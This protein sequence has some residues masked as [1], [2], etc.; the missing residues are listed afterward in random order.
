[1]DPDE[2]AAL[3]RGAV[4]RGLLLGC[5][6]LVSLLVL[7]GLG[8]AMLG[9]G[10]GTRAEATADEA[11][12]PLGPP[13][14][15]SPACAF[16]LGFAEFR[17][18][19]PGVVGACLGDEA[20]DPASGNTVQ[21]TTTGMLEWRRADGLVAFTDGHR[22]WVRGPDGA[23][24][25]RYNDERFP[26]EAEPPGRELRVVTPGPPLVPGTPAAPATGSPDPGELRAYAAY[27]APRF[28]ALTA[29]VT[30]LTELTEEAGRRPAAVGEEEWRAR[31]AITLGVLRVAGTE[32][33][34]YDPV[35]ERLRVLD[36][37]VVEV[38]RELVLVV[39]EFAQGLDDQDTGR[40]ANAARHMESA[41]AKMAAANR[42]MATLT[43]G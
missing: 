4:A 1:V 31:T 9:R 32:I 43:G 24:R 19:A 8:V 29:A 27:M 21:H 25:Q 35:P 20:P 22:T 14:S 3:R 7:V 34:R 38:G 23:V 41:S 36:A 16:L 33:Q 2:D 28:E 5:L 42:E 13:P 37:L 39:D 26:F 18:A 30:S 12:A 15:P 40:I 11:A 10:S 17:D 6:G